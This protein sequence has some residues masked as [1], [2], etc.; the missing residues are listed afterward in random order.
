MA[1]DQRVT[2]GRVQ[3]DLASFLPSLISLPEHILRIGKEEDAGH[4]SLGR[5]GDESVPLYAIHFAKEVRNSHLLILGDEDGK[6]TLV[7]TSVNHRDT[8]DA[9]PKAVKSWTA[10]G[11]S[12]LESKW[13][14]HDSKILTCS[15]DETAALW[16]VETSTCLATFGGHMGTVRSAADHP[17]DPH[18]FT[19]ASRDGAIRIWDTRCSSAA[20]S[21]DAQYRPFN[22]INQAHSP[23]TVAA[24]KKPAFSICRDGDSLKKRQ[25]Q[26]SVYP[27]AAAKFLPHHS[28]NLAIVSAGAVD[29]CLKTWDCR[30]IM[31]HT[32][33]REL[34]PAACITPSLGWN[35]RPF[36]IASLEISNS[37]CFIYATCLDNSIYMLQANNLHST[38]TRLQSQS[39]SFLPT[40]FTKASISSDDRFLA[41]GS[42]LDCVQIWDT[43]RPDASPLLF[44]GHAADVTCVSW[45]ADSIHCLAS[46]S[47]DNTVRLWQPEGLLSSGPIPRTP[48]NIPMHADIGYM[49]PEV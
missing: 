25:K 47:G 24:G 14:Q 22:I 31:A 49:L 43:A 1:S 34:S 45:A 12:I 4:G 48:D 30:S 33:G 7:D 11:E 40:H 41:A 17:V 16:D 32:L 18:F 8:I 44:V 29:G 5:P 42:S 36:G 6:L 15:S 35:R 20:L 10:H 13:C 2:S 3:V 19:T 21:I 23:D 27:V 46:C 9:K 38:P 28:N 37:G 39:H 26:S